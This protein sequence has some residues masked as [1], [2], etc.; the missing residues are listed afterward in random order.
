VRGAQHPL[1]KAAEV[2]T[3]DR[4]TKGEEP[5]CDAES[6]NKWLST[7]GRQQNKEQKKQTIIE[8]AYFL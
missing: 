4:H 5:S 2:S 1:C 7:R 3:S 6:G 8:R